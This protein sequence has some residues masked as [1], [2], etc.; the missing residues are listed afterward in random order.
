ML[1]RYGERPIPPVLGDEVIINDPA[2]AL[3][4]G[5]GLI[6]PS[7]SGSVFGIDKLYSHFPPLFLF[8]QSVSFRLFG[9][10]VY[11]LRLVTTLMDLFA[12]LVFLW[13]LWLLCRWRLVDWGAAPIA[14]CVYLANAALVLMHRTARMESMIEFFLLCGILLILT[15]IYGR[16]K[17]IPPE[18]GSDVP[19]SRLP[20][21]YAG[22]VFD[23][24]AMATHPESLIAVLPSLL[25][26]AF[27]ARVRWVHR[28]LLGVVFAAVPAAIW[29]ATYGRNAI[30]ALHNMG[31]I[32]VYNTPPTGLFY[33]TASFFFK[34]HRNANSGI[35]AELLF[36][37]LG[38]FLLTLVRWFRLE[39]R[40]RTHGAERSAEFNERLMLARIFAL[41]TTLTLILLE[42]FVSASITR[43]EVMFPVLLLGFMLIMRGARITRDIGA[44]T[45]ALLVLLCISQLV[46]IFGSLYHEPAPLPENAA[47]RFDAILERIPRNAH[48][49]AMPAFW[50]AF[51][52]QGRP[53]TLLYQG[54]DGMNE[55]RQ[56]NAENPLRRFDVIITDTSRMDEFNLYTP[57]AAQGRTLQTFTVGDDQVDLF[58]P[59]A[60]SH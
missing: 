20:F 55:W 47:H 12:S 58:T 44:G 25:L 34:T 37:C 57:L 52:Q 59:S 32:L 1:H 36:L 29:W 22:V 9:V 48:V 54:F 56:Q 40:A 15:G 51:E 30:Q 41:S 49:A 43:Y 14:A 35:R 23:G 33:F 16:A 18:S 11:S 5:Q 24:L 53:V 27:A 31:R 26:L 42:W 60:A 17:S 10:S 39:Q 13:V 19:Q 8:A 50:L 21:L 28:F 3:S 2:V 46:A 4:R 38:I 7:F 45:V 6:A